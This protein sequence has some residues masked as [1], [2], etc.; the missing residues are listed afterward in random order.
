MREVSLEVRDKDSVSYGA[1]FKFGGS[2]TTR[3]TS[4]GESTTGDLFLKVTIDNDSNNLY[5]LERD[6]YV[7][8]IDL[9]VLSDVTRRLSRS[10][11]VIDASSTDSHLTGTVTTETARQLM[12]TSIPYDE[13]WNIY[14]DGEKVEI[15]E[16]NNSLVSFYVEGTGEHSIEMKYMP[17]TV[18]LG[19]GVSVICLVVYILILI[20]Y[21]FVKKVPY[22]RRLVMIEGEELPELA[23]AE[24]RAEITAGD[25]GAPEKDRDII[26]EAEAAKYG[27]VRPT[28][29][30]KK[31]AQSGKAP[32]GKPN[33]GSKSKTGIDPKSGKK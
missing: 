7:Y 31:P 27:K 23:T 15:F 29:P 16:A 9:E 8:Y 13:G 4:L 17:A 10:E 3:I 30:E 22:L 2:D 11:F 5:I 33:G 12:F 19:I 20:A 6:S 32:Q 28:V 24:Y 25:I 1:D 18:A 14:V 26:A 21:P